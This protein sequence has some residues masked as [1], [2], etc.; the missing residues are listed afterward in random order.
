MSD[1]WTLTDGWPNANVQNL[2]NKGPGVTLGDPKNYLGGQL[3]VAAGISTNGEIG[4]S[5][6]NVYTDANKALTTADKLR[7]AVLESQLRA[8]VEDMTGIRRYYINIISML[9]AEN[10]SLRAEL[11]EMKEN[12]RKLWAIVNKGEPS[13][14]NLQVRA[15]ETW[16]KLWPE[17][18]VP[19]GFGDA[20]TTPAPVPPVQPSKPAIA[21]QALAPR[22]SQVGVRLP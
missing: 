13:T 14:D 3:V 1:G 17:P 21:A 19:V 9:E 18:S 4:V 6:P 15:T 7:I 5:M 10:A 20:D 2:N 22:P 8:A 11:D 16:T 12:A